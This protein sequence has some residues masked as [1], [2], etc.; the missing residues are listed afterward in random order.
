M[1]ALRLV[2]PHRP[3]ELHDVPTP[4]PGPDDVLIR[5]HA[6]GICHS[7]AHYRNGIANFDGLLPLTL[8]HEVAGT[9]A[10]LGANVRA[11]ASGQRVCVHYLATCGTCAWCAGG[12]EQFCGTGQM[13]GRHRDGGM[14][15]F[16]VMPAA[17]VF[18]LPDAISFAHGAVMMCSSATALHALRKARLAPGETVA[19]FGVGGLGASA[20][21][22][23]RALGAGRVFAVDINADKLALAARFGATPVDARASDPVAEIRRATGGRGADVA[24]ELIG[25]PPTMQQSVR[26]LNKRGRA[27]LAGLTRQP[28]AVDPYHEVINQEA[29]IIG[30][31]DHL[32]TEIP[33]LLRFA[34]D[35]RLQLDPIVTRTVPLDAAAINAVLDDLDRFGSAARTV[36]Q[37]A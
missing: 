6:A 31:S 12:H 18:P 14:A 26:V 17:S 3:V 23:A 29:E 24:L 13:I 7:D 21:Q 32:A 27:A 4:A 25:L 34:A 8:G 36:V 15:E 20:V 37:V 30:V 16:I 33:E 22:L 19:V 28:L 5:V 35:G 11:L 9:V 2:A 1:K 10:A